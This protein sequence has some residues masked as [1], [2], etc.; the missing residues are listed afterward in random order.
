M[1]YKEVQRFSE[2]YHQ[3]L[4]SIEMIGVML[5]DTKSSWGRHIEASISFANKAYKENYVKSRNK[6]LVTVPWEI[7][8]HVLYRINKHY[9]HLL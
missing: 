2:I 8:P 4:I 5:N 7:R 3:S 6:V 1:D 9:Q